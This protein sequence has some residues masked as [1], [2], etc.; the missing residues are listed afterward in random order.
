MYNVLV[1]GATGMLGQ[2]VKNLLT[3]DNRFNIVPTSTT[4]QD[5]YAYYN[6]LDGIEKFEKIMNSQKPPF[7]YIINCIG[8]LSKNIDDKDSKSV[9]RAIQINSLFPHELSLL[10]METGSRVIHISTDGVFGKKSGL[11][12]EDSSC[13][14]HDL[15]GK[16]KSLGELTAPNFLNIRTSIIGPNP[17]RKTGL[18]EWFLSQPKDGEVYGFTDKKWNGVTTLQFAKLCKILILDDYFDTVYAESPIHHFCPNQSKNKYEL[19]KLFRSN[20]RPDL[21]VIPQVNIKKAVSRTLDTNYQ[22][23]SVKFG[24]NIIMKEAIKALASVMK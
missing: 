14:V 24:N 20:F 4:F 22:S 18:L 21:T 15:Y 2:M 9:C 19:L 11:C 17:I 10:A 1:L 8:V 5:S 3:K 13:D 12:K 16:T 7:N 6:V 23:I